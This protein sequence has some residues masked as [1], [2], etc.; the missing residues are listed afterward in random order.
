M[1]FRKHRMFYGYRRRRGGIKLSGSNC[2]CC[3]YAILCI[4]ILVGI[5][6]IGSSIRFLIDGIADTRGQALGKWDDAIISWDNGGLADFQG[7][8]LNLESDGTQMDYNTEII[9]P[10]DFGESSWSSNG[11]NPPSQVTAAFYSAPV[12]PDPTVN[13]VCNF[14]I[15]DKA[16]RQLV[17]R[18]LTP[19]MQ[20]IQRPQSLFC[21]CLIWSSSI[22]S[23]M[24]DF[25]LFFLLNNVNPDIIKSAMMSLMV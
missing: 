3:C 16:G 11:M 9:T 2:V 15:Y 8:G 19:N 17:Q 20:T 6:C 25:N 4:I 5:I 10:R 22:P 14:K 7:L 13:Q 21:R 24:L 1:P 12:C 18:S 23:N